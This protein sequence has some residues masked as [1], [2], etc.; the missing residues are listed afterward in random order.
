MSDYV[1]CEIER[2]LEKPTREELFARIAQLPPI[3]LDPP[4]SDVLRE[5]RESR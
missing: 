4:P 3:E 2:L 5:E 1:L